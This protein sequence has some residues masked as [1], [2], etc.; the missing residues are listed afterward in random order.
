MRIQDKLPIEEQRD[1]SRGGN[2]ESALPPWDEET[3]EETFCETG[4]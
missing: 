1:A 2:P 3:L 4:R